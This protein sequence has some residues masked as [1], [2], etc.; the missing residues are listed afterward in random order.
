MRPASNS[1][2]TDPNVETPGTE[3]AEGR[4]DLNLP[5]AERQ[6]PPPDRNDDLPERLGKRIQDGPGGSG[7]ATGESDLLPNVDVPT[8]TM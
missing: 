5:G 3:P 4:A 8:E 1:P 6:D 2:T 7:V